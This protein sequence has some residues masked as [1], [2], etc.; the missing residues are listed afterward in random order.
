MDVG[1]LFSP[2]RS[3]LILLRVEISFKGVRRREDVVA[4]NLHFLSD[5]LLCHSQMSDEF[6]NDRLWEEIELKITP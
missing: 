4:H 2:S 6:L 5:K 3:C 1:L